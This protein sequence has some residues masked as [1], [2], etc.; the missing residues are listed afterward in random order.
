TGGNASVPLGASDLT[1]TGSVWVPSGAAE[2]LGETPDAGFTFVGWVGNGS[3]NYTGSA[4]A[5]AVY[6]TGPVTEV[7]QFLPQ[8][9]SAAPTFELTFTVPY[10]PPSGLAW[11]VTLGTTFY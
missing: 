1:V 7:A 5:P 10:A 9:V 4:S 2:T 3:G 8:V 6:P 11:G